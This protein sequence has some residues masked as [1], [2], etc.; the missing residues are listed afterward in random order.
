M[1]GGCDSPRRRTEAGLDIEKFDF[2]KA[3]GHHEMDAQDGFRTYLVPY[4]P[5]TPTFL[6]LFVIFADVAG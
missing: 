5:V 2:K 1:V 6:V 4:L 3:T